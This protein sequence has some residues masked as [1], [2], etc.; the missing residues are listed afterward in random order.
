MS[1][2]NLEIPVPQNAVVDPP[3]QVRRPWRAT[4]RT[5]F[6]AIVGVAPILPMAYQA[7]TQQ[8]PALATGWVG[9][10]LAIA[11]GIT[12]VMAMASVNEFFKKFVPFLAPEPKAD[13]QA[14]RR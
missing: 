2:Q 12:R 7:A 1:E 14:R 3:T 13:V 8:D 5:I 11:G 6:A 4:V 9:T 10:G